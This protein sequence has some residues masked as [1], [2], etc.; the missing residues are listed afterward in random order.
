VVR[1]LLKAGA[2]PRLTLVANGHAALHTAAGAGH[3]AICQLLVSAAATKTT[4]SAEPRPS[5]TNA[6]DHAGWT[7]L[8]VASYHGKVAVVRYLVT[9]A[10]DAIHVETRNRDGR[11]ALQVASRQTRRTV[12][13]LDVVRL[14]QIEAG[15]SLDSMDDGGATPL[16]SAVERCDLAMLR[17]L[18]RS[19]ATVRRADLVR[20]APTP[21]ALY[22]LLRAAVSQGLL[23]RSPFP[24]SR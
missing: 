13:R 8:H 6:V 3:V 9:Q 11:T 12:R 19:G 24:S 5:L 18:L 7:A 20:A 15:A 1:L 16:G 4:D 2:D 22:P 17:C 14:L 21:D 10:V 23:S